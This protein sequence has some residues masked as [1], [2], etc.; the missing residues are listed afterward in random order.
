LR[1]LPGV[2]LGAAVLRRQEERQGSKEVK[3]QRKQ[4]KQT[5]QALRPACVVCGV[6]RQTIARFVHHVV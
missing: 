5:T 2:A 1:P 4:R 3:K 6:K